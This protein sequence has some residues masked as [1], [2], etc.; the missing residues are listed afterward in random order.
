M[1]LYV[2]DWSNGY[3]SDLKGYA[4]AVRYIGSPG[5]AKN[6]TKP[7]VAQWRAQGVP[8]SF[9]HEQD[10]GW[11]LGGHLR[12]QSAGLAV[13]KD[14]VTLGL[15]LR[16]V[17]AACDFKPSAAQMPLVLA[18]L[19]GFGE[20]LGHDVASVYGSASVLNAA[21]AAG[22][23]PHGGWQTVAWSYVNGKLVVSPYAVL[24][25]HTQQI[26]L[27]GVKCDLNT[28]NAKDWRQSPAP[29]GV[30]PI[31]PAS[32]PIPKRHYYP[33]RFAYTPR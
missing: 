21:H 26:T 23:L 17:F 19:K 24:L 27:H 14:A 20:I 15:T 22:L 5:H 8:L 1:A 25:Q 31:P 6:L 12:G 13:H 30:T 10:A 32:A 3:P 2:L 28:V 18:C 29:S 33:H 4:G 11:M 7:E 9:V 16:G